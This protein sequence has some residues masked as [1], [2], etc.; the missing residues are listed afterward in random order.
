M[1]AGTVTLRASPRRIAIGSATPSTAIRSRGPWTS[2]KVSATGWPC[3]TTISLG[4]K[5]KSR[6]PQVPSAFGWRAAEAEP[7][8]DRDAGAG[9]HVAYLRTPGF[10]ACRETA[11]EQS[12]LGRLPS[13]V[14]PLP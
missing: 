11:G 6:T 8:E 9:P 13:A 4:W 12:R 3:S 1:P 5:T 7:I 2:A 10:H 14:M